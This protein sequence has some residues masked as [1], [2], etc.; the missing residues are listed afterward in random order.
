VPFAANNS[1]T[2]RRGRG[3]VKSAPS[4]VD[5]L[6]PAPPWLARFRL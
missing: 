1:S 6:T 5:A 2:D 3:G 4:A